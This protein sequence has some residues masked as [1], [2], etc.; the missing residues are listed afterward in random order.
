MNGRVSLVTVS[1]L[2]Q[3]HPHTTSQRDDEETDNHAPMDPPLSGGRCGLG[4]CGQFVA[5]FGRDLLR[6]ADAIK[7]VEN[8]RF[9]RCFERR[10][11]LCDVLLD[12][13]E[14]LVATV[15]RKFV[16]MS[17]EL[18]KVLTNRTVTCRIHLVPFP[19][20]PSTASRNLCHSSANW[21]RALSPF[22]V[23]R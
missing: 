15:C 23:S 13:R 2:E 12:L 10:K 9:G 3:D 17:L 7:D 5:C 20:K 6:V 16:H 19:T 4:R 22:A 14:D 11:S 1:P 8:V 21:S 18:T